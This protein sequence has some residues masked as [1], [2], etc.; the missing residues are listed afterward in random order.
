[1]EECVVRR[2]LRFFLSKI[3]VLPRDNDVMSSAH[4]HTNDGGRRNPGVVGP[5][6]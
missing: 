6:L 2:F 3:S 1:M 5:L 4:L